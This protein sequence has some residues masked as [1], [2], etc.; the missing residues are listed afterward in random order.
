MMLRIWLYASNLLTL[1]VVLVMTG[2]LVHTSLPFWRAFGIASLL[3]P[4]WYPYEDNF[5]LLAAW[6]GSAWAAFLA[7]AVALPSGLAA[8]LVSAELLPRR[9]RLG[10][11]ILMELLAAVP[12]VV[13][14]LVGLWLLLPSLQR[15]FD[16]PTGH[17]LLAAGLLLALMIV[18]TFTAL[19]EDAIAAVPPQQREAALALG[20]SWPALVGRVVLP[21]AW[22][23]LRSATILSLNRAL[24]ETMAV[25]LV[26]GSIDRLPTP[27]WNLLQPAQTLTSRIGREIGEAVFGS[28]HFSALM[29]C[30]FLLAVSG[31]FLGWLMHRG[32]SP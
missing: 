25:M 13:Y 32:D 26:V 7:L 12:S 8:A 19:A 10:L 11:R 4:D 2:F 29:A 17:S 16:L 20:L 6:V 23:G 24:G 21:Q 1:L 27:W 9:W 28:M 30:A 14:G 3:D 31:A 18:P 15:W 5:G 22:P